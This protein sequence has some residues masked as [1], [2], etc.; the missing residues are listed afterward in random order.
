MKAGRGIGEHVA[1]DQR[2]LEQAPRLAQLLLPRL[3]LTT[4]WH[5]LPTEGFGQTL[6]YYFA[7]PASM[8]GDIGLDGAGT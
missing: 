8:R 4:C 1:Q 7:W 2:T 6:R 3:T 5:F